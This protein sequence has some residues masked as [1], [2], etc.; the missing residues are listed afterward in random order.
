MQNNPINGLITV[1]KSSSRL[2]GKC[3]L[4]FGHESI[5]S[6][7]VKRAVKYN[8]RPII[9]TSYDESDNDIEKLAK[10]MNVDFYR[11]PLENKL[12]RWSECAKKY[13][14]K[15]FHT[16]DADDPFFDGALVLKSMQLLDKG[17]YD[18]ISPTKS[19]S[20][21]AASV[22]Y[23]LSSE[24]VHKASNK[25][26]DEL[27]TEMMWYFLERVQDIKMIELEDE[28]DKNLKMRLTLDY[29]E[30]YHLLQFIQRELGSM[31]SRKDINQLFLSN[32]D[33]HKLNWF[34]NIEWK[35]SQLAKKI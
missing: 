19:S 14:L 26:S 2:P 28:E 5:L 32:P 35:E 6:H 20:A 7:I 23:S 30:D 18:V 31:A 10:N 11:G 4:P 24:I 9:C 8:I 1:R 33:L 12:K 34:R 15:N 21:G 3:F 27:D 17:N 13:N 29:I 22:G 25:T 16:I